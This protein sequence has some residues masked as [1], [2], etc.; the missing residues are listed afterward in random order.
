MITSAS[1][2]IELMPT[3]V[4]SA[5]IR[6]F[7]GES[8]CFTGT[9]NFLR[10]CSNLRALT[11]LNTLPQAGESPTKGFALKSFNSLAAAII[12]AGSVWTARR[13]DLGAIKLG[14][15]KTVS[16]RLTNFSSPPRSSNCAA[17]ASV[18]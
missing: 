14:L 2:A 8:S 17:I 18:I 6:H 4:L 9:A 15:S 5:P 1:S 13:R 16:P 12:T 3:A 7:F 10:G 11:Q